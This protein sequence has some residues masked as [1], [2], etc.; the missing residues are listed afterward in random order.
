MH[1]TKKTIIESHRVEPSVEAYAELHLGVWSITLAG[2]QH[3]LF[4]TDLMQMQHRA[5]W[6]RWIEPLIFFDALFRHA[7]AP[8]H[9]CDKQYSKAQHEAMISEV[10][11]SIWKWALF[12]SVQR[13]IFR[14]GNF[15]NRSQSEHRSSLFH[16]LLFF[17]SFTV[18]R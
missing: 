15:R 1:R 7:L 14:L 5:Q 6:T 10:T 8:G 18:D 16:R 2:V 12:Q 9:M 11:R 17:S 3:I 13:A 4:H